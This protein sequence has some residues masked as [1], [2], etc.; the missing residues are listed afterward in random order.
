M[1]IAAHAYNDYYHDQLPGI[2]TLRRRLTDGHQEG[3]WT[4]H[5]ALLPYLKETDLYNSINWSFAPDDGRVNQTVIETRVDVFLCPSDHGGL[6]SYAVNAGTWYDYDYATTGQ[7][8]WDGL[9]AHHSLDVNVFQAPGLNRLQDGT[10]NT[11]MFAEQVHSP[12][13]SG[14][15]P[16]PSQRLMDPGVELRMVTPQQARSVCLSMRDGEPASARY[17]HQTIGQSEE[18][19]LAAGNT[20]PSFPAVGQYWALAMPNRG[21]FVNGLLPPNSTNCLGGYPDSGNRKDAAFG[22]RCASSW[23]KAGVNVAFADGSVYFV[24]ENWNPDWYTALFSI[25]RNEI[26]GLDAH[27]EPF[28]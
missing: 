28:Q 1:V 9:A 24:P 19:V 5:A 6:N 23:H 13:V 7:G 27:S 4:W 14:L 2:A 25:D 15:G 17:V 22:L 20:F 12:S 8:R 11:I 21:A 16:A 26:T 10:S 3:G 18:S